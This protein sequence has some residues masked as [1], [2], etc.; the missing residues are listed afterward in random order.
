MS[1]GYEQ[2][3]HLSDA[4]ARAVADFALRGVE[5]PEVYKREL[6]AHAKCFSAPDPFASERRAALKSVPVL[7]YVELWCP[8]SPSPA[9]QGQLLLPL[10]RPEL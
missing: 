4:A 10:R 7:T 8:W 5:I 3:A 2:S 9:R 6:R 1:S